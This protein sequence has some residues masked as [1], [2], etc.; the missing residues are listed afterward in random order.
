MAR[1]YVVD[2][3]SDTSWKTHDS[4]G[5]TASYATRP[6]MMAVISESD[7]ETENHTDTSMPL[8]NDS[9]AGFRFTGN[10]VAPLTE[11]PAQGG[12]LRTPGNGCTNCSY[13]SGCVSLIGMRNNLTNRNGLKCSSYVAG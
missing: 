12:S 7:I 8:G 3:I 13:R 1:I 4:A 2:R 5:V 10:G 11:R 9:S 6:L